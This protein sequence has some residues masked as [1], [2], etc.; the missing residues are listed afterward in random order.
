MTTI[1][2]KSVRAGKFV[3]TNHVNT[4]VSTYKK[5]RWAANSDRMG[6]EDSLSVWYS[7][8]ELEEFLMRAKE[9]G[10]DGVRMHFGAY[11]A[12]FAKKPEV[13]DLQTIVMVANATTETT[14]GKV[15]KNVFVETENG[16]QILAYNMGGLLPEGDGI[17]ADGVGITIV[18]RADKG[19]TV[20]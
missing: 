4:L 13:S 5:T 20:I 6:K 8:E 2:K 11:P 12:N 3:D 19:F 17:S 7:I 15:E 18:E 9:C 16:R 1:E 10:A 14:A